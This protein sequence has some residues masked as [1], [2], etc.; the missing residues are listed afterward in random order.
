MKRLGSLILSL[1]AEVPAVAHLTVLAAGCYPGVLMRF[2]SFIFLPSH[3]VALGIGVFLLGVPAAG[4]QP[5]APSNAVSFD[6]LSPECRIPPS[7][8]YS[9][10]PLQQVRSAVEQRHRLKVLAL[11]PTSASALA[12]GTGLAPFPIR[13][14][15]ELEKVLPGVDVIVDARS[16][17]GEITAQASPTIMNLVSEVEPELIVWQVGISEALAQAD[18]GSFSE[19]LNEVLAFFRAHRIDAVL[20]EPPYTAAL[21]SDDHFAEVV[22]AISARARENGVVLISR[23]AAMRYVAE[24]RA[25]AGRSRF[26]LQNR[27]YHC[28]AEHVGLVVRLSLERFAGTK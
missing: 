1:M 24:Q 18:V 3:A 19:A 27:G 7:L 22:A 12:P 26:E 11:G 13:L 9:L 16:L 15:H 20:V 23:S 5:D 10:A 6:A 2:S 14:E 8:L 4:Q 25:E 28:T 21:A 17:S